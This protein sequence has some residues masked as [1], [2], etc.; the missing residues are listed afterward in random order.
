MP[1]SLYPVPGKDLIELRARLDAPD[2]M[3]DISQDLRPGD[4]FLGWPREDLCALG[5]VCTN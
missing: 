3:G 2:A 5:M 4:S 1:F